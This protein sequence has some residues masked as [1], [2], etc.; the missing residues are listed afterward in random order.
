MAPGDDDDYGGGDYQHTPHGWTGNTQQTDQS[1]FQPPTHPFV[2]TGAPPRRFNQFAAGIDRGYRQ[3]NGLVMKDGHPVPASAQRRST[4]YE[5]NATNRSQYASQ[6]VSQD[7]RP[8][9]TETGSQPFSFA[10]PQPRRPATQ[11][12]QFSALPMAQSPL[13][14]ADRPIASIE[15]PLYTNQDARSNAPQPQKTP[16][17]FPETSPQQPEQQPLYPRVPRDDGV[18]DSTQDELEDFELDAANPGATKRKLFKADRPRY[19]ENGHLVTALE[20]LKT[21]GPFTQ[22]SLRLNSATS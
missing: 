14:Q 21:P 9:Q 1:S 5:H 22:E 13:K 18:D 7:Q 16:G 17:A 3:A 4:P 10:A 12:P 11:L 20:A 2:P 15:Q 19:D 6:T 8:T